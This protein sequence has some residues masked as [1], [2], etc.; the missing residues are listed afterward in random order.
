MGTSARSLDI[1]SRLGQGK[2]MGNPMSHQGKAFV[3]EFLSTV[4]RVR[5][6]MPE[7]KIKMINQPELL[8][9]ERI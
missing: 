1:S 4:D 8:E 9:L 5:T 7:W 3:N 2:S 6:G